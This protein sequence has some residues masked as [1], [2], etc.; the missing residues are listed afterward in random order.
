MKTTVPLPLK[1]VVGVGGRGLSHPPTFTP[2]P[3]IL[4][5]PSGMLP[6][7]SPSTSE[8]RSWSGVAHASASKQAQPARQTAS[9]QRTQAPR[10]QAAS[11]LSSI[12]ALDPAVLT[13]YSA[14]AYTG[15]LFLL[16]GV[17]VGGGAGCCIELPP[18]LQHNEPR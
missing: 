17:D 3:S 5:R 7:C 4:P 11:T 6:F 14:T 1:R 9:T 13:L 18:S 2:V 8:P 10:G 16:V 12:A 15:L